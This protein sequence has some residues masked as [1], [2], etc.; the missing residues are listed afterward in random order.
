MA[1]KIKKVKEKNKG[2]TKEAKNEK[3]KTEKQKKTKK[4]LTEQEQ[5]NIA[6]NILA[7]FCIGL[8]S[9][10][11]VTKMFQNDTFY[12]IKIGQLIRQNGIDYKDHFS[13]QSNLPYMYPHWLYD[14]IISLI[15]DYC[16]G[17]AGIYASTVVLSVILGITLFYADKR[18]SKNRVISLFMAI[19]Q[20][21]LMTDYVAARAQLVTFILFALTIIFIEKFLESPK[22]RYAFALILIPIIIA[23]VHSAVFPFYFVLYLPYI[24]EYIICV[25]ADSHLI[26]KIHQWELKRS[27][28]STNKKLKNAP[29]EKAEVY[30]KKLAELNKKVEISNS[31]FE[32]SLVKQAD[33]RK[34]PY[35]IKL[36][37]NDN[38]LKL[39]VIMCICFF[40]G[41]L[42]PIKDMPYTYTVRIM[43][44]N[45]TSSIS[46][47]VPLTLIE[48]KGIMVFIVGTI[49]FLA[50][51]KIKIRLKDLF[52]LGGLTLLAFMTRRQV[53]MLALIGG[54]ST[55]KMIADFV[56]MYD[57][58]GTD[59]L[60]KYLTSLVGEIIL[61]VFM[62][63]IS[64]CAY[65]P[66]ANAPY[67]NES[68][69]PVKAATWIKENLDY[70]N[71]RL[72]N[73]YNYGSYLLFQDIPVFIDSRCD[74]YTP[75]FNGT[76][77][78]EKKKYEGRDIFSDSINT[79]SISK[80][81]ENTFD[82]YGVT[83]LL[84]KK[85]SKLNMLLSKNDNY[86]QLYSDDQFVVIERENT[87][88][89][90]AKTAEANN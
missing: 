6:F 62:L 58:K 25:L 12:T 86:K 72:Y 45:T 69:Y 79:S 63:V 2:K 37:R 15:Y 88:E 13:W 20:M 85:S 27:I 51:T 54:M 18:V 48:N 59:E 40:T 71:I 80:Y 53:S 81:Y 90:V 14:V 66:H 32:K 82:E 1:E 84:I 3:P 78:K 29:K 49:A 35:K 42:T 73:D 83:H 24:G 33:R 52:F 16:G 8:F 26:H 28:K 39:V 22:K 65:K 7:I 34:N 21:Y 4:K 46:E 43:K 17:F 50:F 30:Q 87:T 47:H 68:S 89:D 74:L 11:I 44:G 5:I 38:V 64:Y 55:T 19:A 61:V 36:V 41:F 75:E 31:D 70:K 9:A 77:N 76:Y 10:A 23:N 57:K 56:D 60:T 67:V